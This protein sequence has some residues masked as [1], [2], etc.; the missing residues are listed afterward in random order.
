M[1]LTAFVRSQSCDAHTSAYLSVFSL[2]VVPLIFCAASVPSSTTHKCW[3]TNNGKTMAHAVELAHSKDHIHIFRCWNIQIYPYTHTHTH[4]MEIKTM[5]VGVRVLSLQPIKPNA[6][7]L[8]IWSSSRI[9]FF[10]L[11]YL[12]R[13]L[14]TW[15][16]QCTVFLPRCSTNQM[17][18][19]VADFWCMPI[20]QWVFSYI[21]PPTHLPYSFQL[22]P[23]TPPSLSVF[24][25]LVAV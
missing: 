4:Y 15:Y 9:P 17:N 11:K 25:V 5:D 20:R 23:M 7:S 2:D 12:R 14:M 24:F 3:H 21:C 16:S 1:T 13:C 6:F 19:C 22:T 10:A 18:L 8:M